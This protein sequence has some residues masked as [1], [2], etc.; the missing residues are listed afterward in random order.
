MST[1][2]ATN[3]QYTIVARTP[4][5]EVVGLV[6]LFRHAPNPKVHEIGELMIL[7]SY[8]NSH[9]AVDLSQVAGGNCPKRFGLQVLFSETV[10]NHRVSQRLA[11]Q[12]GMVPTGLE[13][14][15]MPAGAYKK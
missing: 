15:C 1:P 3:D 10:C 9:L 6:G 8:R 7:K 13:L 12:Q 14:E 5:G 4:K 2:N 11:L